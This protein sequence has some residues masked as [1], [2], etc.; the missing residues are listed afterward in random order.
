M[1]AELSF[2][3]NTK[4]LRRRRGGQ[5]S[6]GAIITISES[7]CAELSHTKSVRVLWQPVREQLY[8]T[9]HNR[10]EI[11]WTGAAMIL[12]LFLLCHSRSLPLC[13]FY[14]T[15]DCVYCN[16]GIRHKYNV[17]AWRHTTQY[18]LWHRGRHTMKLAHKPL[19]HSFRNVTTKNQQ[20]NVSTYGD[21][22]V[23]VTLHLLDTVR[24]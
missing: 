12:F 17:L 20:R 24:M 11:R 6:G 4:S 1:P 13:I 15:Y 19:L 3:T 23:C 14:W 8:W 21:V 22:Y 2:T 5:K 16:T 18:P 10:K 7:M 9:T